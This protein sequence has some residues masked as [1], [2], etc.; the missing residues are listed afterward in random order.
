[1]TR[2]E[3][4]DTCSLCEQRYHGV[5][6]CALGWAA[7]KTYVGRPETDMARRCAMT[8]LGNGLSTVRCHEDALSVR[9]AELSMERRLGASEISILVTQNNLAN[10]YRAIGRHE[11]ALRMRQEVYSV[12]LKLLGEE[13]SQT[14]SAACNYANLL[15]D[16][17]RFEEAKSLLL[18]ATPLARR[19]FGESHELTLKMRWIYAQTL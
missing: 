2:W 5:V 14:I 17:K 16:L 15:V 4:W 13:N 8:E 10:T 18:K 11:E 9:E 12:R 19:V 6:S 7:W 1:M 3:R